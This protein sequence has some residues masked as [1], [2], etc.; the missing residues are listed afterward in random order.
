[1][2]IY[3]TSTEQMRDMT[4]EEE[5]IAEHMP[6]PEEQTDS[7]EALNILLGGEQE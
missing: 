3:D 2:L 4:A 6:N 1:M 5:Y 7:D